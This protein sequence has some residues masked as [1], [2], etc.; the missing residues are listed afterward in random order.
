MRPKNGSQKGK[1]KKKEILKVRA[2]M[3]PETIKLKNGG[4]QKRQQVRGQ[5]CSNQWFR[6]RG[7]ERVN[8]TARERAKRPS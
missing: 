1:G 2:K 3:S 8:G 7:R 5:S 4:S 6:R